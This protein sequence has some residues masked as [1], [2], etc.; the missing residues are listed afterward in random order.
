MTPLQYTQQLHQELL[1]FDKKQVEL[2]V[3]PL[4]LEQ[5]NPAFNLD[6]YKDIFHP[7]LLHDLHKLYTTVQKISV[8]WSLSKD[9]KG[10]LLTSNWVQKEVLEDRG[11][12]PEECLGGNL[13]IVSFQEMMSDTFYTN[14]LNQKGVEYLP[15]DRHWT[16]VACLKKVNGQVK[17]KVYFFDSENAKKVYDLKIG[18]LNYI[19]LAYQAK[20][21]YNWQYA[22][23]FQDK[24]N[25]YNKHL[26]IMLPHLLPHLE[27]DLSAFG[28]DTS[29]NFDLQAAAETDLTADTKTDFKEEETRLVKYLK[30]ID[31]KV[32]YGGL[33]HIT[34]DSQPSHI[35][36]AK[37]SNLHRQLA[38]Q[39]SASAPKILLQ[40]V[41]N[42]C[43]IHALEK[44]D[45]VTELHLNY[46]GDGPNNFEA[47]LDKDI[48]SIETL[49]LNNLVGVQNLDFLRSFPNLSTLRLSLLKD[50][51]LPE[52]WSFCKNLK[53]I[54]IS[55]DK[56]QHTGIQK[57]ILPDSTLSLTI[58]M[59]ALQA[60]PYIKGDQL[61]Y[62][63]LSSTQISKIEQLEHLKNIQLLKIESSA[64]SKVEGLEGLV[65]LKSLSLKNNKLEDFS[66]LAALPA[67]TIVYLSKKEFVT[68]DRKTN[69]KRKLKLKHLKLTVS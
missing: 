43:N 27:L 64:I 24:E 4:I 32:S 63:A 28:I 14:F 39:D 58:W 18:V 57:L 21:F 51:R 12:S 29:S 30:T 47:W 34:F 62:L 66:N 53:T 36:F 11:L 46:I 20:C 42:H 49:W 31:S 8:F 61:Q 10:N 41:P 3:N 25:F 9:K 2:S 23:L 19:Q 45:S 69:L 1:A 16:R 52:D 13:N 17:N 37:F 15:F 5:P 59:N 44:A 35:D 68:E 33:D 67:Q 38:T 55:A 22:F 7:D 54:S 50:N 65:N 60:I 26:G 6:N 56:K 40:N 48:P